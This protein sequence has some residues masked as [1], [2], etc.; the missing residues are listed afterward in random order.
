MADFAFV[1]GLL[2]ALA[3][4]FLSA[5]HRVSGPAS[6]TMRSAARIAVTVTLSLLIV[7]AATYFVSNSRTF[8]LA[9]R[10]VDHVDTRQKVIA[11]TFDDGPEPGYTEQTLSVLEAHEASATF[12]VTGEASTRNPDQVREIIAAGDELGNHTYSHGALYF[13]PEAQVAQEIEKTDT[14]LR[15]AG[16]IGPLTFRP[17][18]CKK[19]LTAP[20]YLSNAGRTTVTWNLEP[21]SIAEIAND[22]NAMTRYVVDN[23]RPG[24]IVLMHVMYG[25]REASRE[26]L[27]QILTQLAA[28]GYRFVTVS[29]AL[30]SAEMQT[31]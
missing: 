29:Q 15:A 13:V 30:R 19:L 28:Q 17:P 24:S 23:A 16:Y 31:P 22:A 18:G 14:V 12:Y 4:L 5:W 21:D 2:A 8:Q 25:S 6:S 27:P 1:I 10:L 7:G 11:L 9:G 26:A 3:L 20:L